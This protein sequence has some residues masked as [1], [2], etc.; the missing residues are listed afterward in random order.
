MNASIIWAARRAVLCGSLLA[1]G[2]AGNSS[3][4]DDWLQFLGPKGAAKSLEAKLPPTTWSDT[5]HLKWSVDLP[6]RGVSSPIVIGDRVV[7]T[8]YSGYGTGA[9]DEAMENLV[10]HVVCVDRADGKV[11]WSKDF[12]STQ[13]EDPYRPPGVTAHGYASHTPTSDGERIYAF[14][15]K[16][17]V[18]ALDFDGHEL[19]QA[20]VGAGSGPQRWG[21]AASPVIHENLL[22]VPAT[23]ESEAVIALDKATGKEV[24]RS[25]AESFQ[26]T[27]STPSVLSAANAAGVTQTDIVISVPGEVWGLNPETGKLRW[28]SRGTTDNSTSASLVPGDGV[29]YATGGRSGDAVAVKLGGKG[30]VNESNVVWDA[31]IPGRFAT[32]VLHEGHLYSFAN[33]V[34]TCFEA[35]T[36]ERVKQQR[37]GE[38]REEGGQGGGDSGGRRGGGGGMGNQ[39][40]ASPVLAGDKLYVTTKSGAVYVLKATP[41]LEIVATNRLSD[42]TGFDGTPAISSG[43]LFFRSGSKLYCVAQ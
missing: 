26:G 31:N 8:C 32:P 28:Y 2:V 18:I 27:W 14:F 22:I 16:G 20:N 38:G 21:S 33:G 37:L 11:L 13:P 35:A 43:E 10:R 42:S 23:E 41:E 34:V 17:G 7:V 4:A 30:D 36:G 40:Y 15:G 9:A 29:V 24:W 25:E 6:G 12:K 3:L 39:D 1:A 19:W 5:E